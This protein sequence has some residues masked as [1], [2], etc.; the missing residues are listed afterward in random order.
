MQEKKEPVVI[1]QEDLFNFPDLPYQRLL[2][3]PY[4]WSLR[5]QQPAMPDFSLFNN[6]LKLEPSKSIK[7]LKLILEDKISPDDEIEVKEVF[8]TIM[9]I[10]KM[11][12]DKSVE[13]SS[14]Y[15]MSAQKIKEIFEIEVH[16]LINIA[17]QEESLGLT[18]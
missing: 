16:K 14:R 13:L 1:T 2:S 3:R 11:H 12:L 17:K 4:H 5:F 7:A 10:R 9:A 18:L 8:N 15:G 6:I